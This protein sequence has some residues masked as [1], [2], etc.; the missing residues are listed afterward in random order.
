MTYEELL[1]KYAP[2]PNARPEEVA[3]AALGV[4]A[5]S[6]LGLVVAALAVGVVAELLRITE[7][8]QARVKVEP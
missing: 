1:A 4:A 8:L 5:T 7:A 3:Q 6:A 2:R